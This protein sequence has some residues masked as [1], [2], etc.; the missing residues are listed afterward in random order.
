MFSY[1]IFNVSIS[2]KVLGCEGKNIHF[3]G[4]WF[5]PKDFNDFLHRRVAF[6]VTLKTRLG[7]VKKDQ[8]PS[9]KTFSQ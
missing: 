2:K 1:V 9:V 8:N 5:L 3:I 7:C 6:F 4:W